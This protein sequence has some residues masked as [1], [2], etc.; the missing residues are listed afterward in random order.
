MFSPGLRKPD[1][2]S[3]ENHVSL[4]PDLIQRDYT[5]LINA[6]PTVAKRTAKRKEKKFI[7]EEEESDNLYIKKNK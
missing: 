6:K 7:D 3:S 5:D 1:T 4:K 2:N